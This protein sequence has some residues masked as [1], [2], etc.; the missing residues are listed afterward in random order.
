MKIVLDTNCLL[1]AIFDNSPYSWL[2]EAFGEGKFHLCSSTEMLEKNTR[3]YWQVFILW[4]LVK[5]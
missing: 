4:K 3:N 5:V 2:W 1:P